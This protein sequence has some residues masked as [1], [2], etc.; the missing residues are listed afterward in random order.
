MKTVKI[1]QESLIINAETLHY[2]GSNTTI[3]PIREIIAKDGRYYVVEVNHVGH[4]GMVTATITEE[5]FL[6]LSPVR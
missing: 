3:T 1:L 4:D 2:E 6:K 5:E